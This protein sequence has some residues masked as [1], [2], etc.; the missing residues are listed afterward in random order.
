MRALARTILGIPLLVVVVGCSGAATPS[1]PPAAAGAPAAE[2]DGTSTS[3]S[4]ATIARPATLAD[5]AAVT[6]TGPAEMNVGS[7]P[8]FEWTAVDGA[9]AY[10]LVVLGPDAPRWA[11]TGTATSVQY[12]GSGAAGSPTLKPGSWWSVAALGA[13]GSVMALSDL[14]AVSP[15]DEPGPTPA[16]ASGLPAAASSEPAEAPADAGAP[17]ANLTACALVTTDE[18]EAILG[19]EFHAGAPS[20]FAIASDDCEFGTDKLASLNV[21]LAPRT[22][23]HPDLWAPGHTPIPGLGEDSF[24]VKSGLDRKVGFVRGEHAVLL[25][26]SFGRVD[27]DAL[28]ELAKAIDARL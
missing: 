6:L 22:G 21:D 26:F 10:R 4:V 3:T 25:S 12:G 23:F 14:R 27:E 19:R 2:A 28:I 5:L 8:T 17:A 7:N 24:S 15:G 11:W 16:W 9:A 1:A 18:L 13:D 20:G